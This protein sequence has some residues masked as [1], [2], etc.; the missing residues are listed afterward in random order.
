M[1]AYWNTESVWG[2][3][4]IDISTGKQMV[5]DG[6]IGDILS[7]GIAPAIVR[8][9]AALQ[10]SA[11]ASV[12][13]GMM[14]NVGA[15][16]AAMFGGKKEYTARDYIQDGLVCLYD[17]IENVAFDHRH[18]S[19]ASVWNS[20]VGGY[21]F[22]FKNGTFD[23]DSFSVTENIIASIKGFKDTI[24]TGEFTIELVGSAADWV[25]L[26]DVTHSS[27][28][29]QAN[30]AN[31]SSALLM[32][33]ENNKIETSSGTIGPDVRQSFAVAVSG[34][35]DVTMYIPSLGLSQD[36]V[37]SSPATE[38]YYGYIW[39]NSRQCRM[40]CYSRKLTADEIEHNHEVDR[41]RFGIL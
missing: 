23:D 30:P 41:A 36:A 29:I 32:T 40:S 27:K 18:D 16:N 10:G 37:L 12:A 33:R 28:Y 19:S 24:N 20:L 1:P 39:K 21:K 4:M 38:V 3:R 11:N 6:R 14:R 26:V 22:I 13:R 35:T 31:G 25:G 34:G 9:D 17:A 15:R 7:S 8:G 2:R 5:G